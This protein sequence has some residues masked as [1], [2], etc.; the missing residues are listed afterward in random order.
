MIIL[1]ETGPA[2]SHTFVAADITLHDV[3]DIDI[4][5]FSLRHNKKVNV[6]KLL[7]CMLNHFRRIFLLACYI[8]SFAE[9]KQVVHAL[10]ILSRVDYQLDENEYLRVHFLGKAAMVA[11]LSGNKYEV[12]GHG[13]DIYAWNNLKKRICMRASS[14]ECISFFGQGY[15]LA[16]LGPAA[17]GKIRVKRNNFFHF[18]RANQLRSEFLFLFVGRFV[19]QKDPLFAVQVFSEIHKTAPS[20]RFILV[21]DG[22]LLIPAKDKARE[23]NIS[24]ACQF[25]GVVEN[26]QVQRLMQQGYGLIVPCAENSLNEADGLPVVFQEAIQQECKIF[27]RNVWGVGELITK[28]NGIA[29]D[30]KISAEDAAEQILG[31]RA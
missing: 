18:P 15:L 20:S 7:A 27:T 1:H 26:E 29:L 22:P 6:Y 21:G 31:F 23:L 16:K 30:I 19:E 5:D 17:V 9:F 24:G 10:V 2:Y 8:R 12:I 14:L 28:D 11:Y 3:G 25:L 13:R 4:F